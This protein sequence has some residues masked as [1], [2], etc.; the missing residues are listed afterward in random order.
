MTA[1]INK[2]LPARLRLL[3]EAAGLSRAELATRAI[4]PRAPGNNVGR[5]EN[6]A[7]NPTPPTLAKIAFGLGVTADFLTTGYPESP[8][9]SAAGWTV[10]EGFPARLRAASA[11]LGV[12]VFEKSSNRAWTSRAQVTAL[13]RGEICPSPE[14]VV[15]LA[16]VLGISAEWL[17]TGT[18]GVAQPAAP[19]PE[20]DT[21]VEPVAPTTGAGGAKRKR[22]RPAKPKAARPA[23]RRPHN[24]GATYENTGTAPEGWTVDKQFPTRLRT[25]MKT[26]GV[27]NEVLAERLGW[28]T[29]NA[30]NSYTTGKLAPR[31]ET[32]M[33]MAVALGVSGHWLATGTEGEMTKMSEL[34]VG[35]RVRLVRKAANLTRAQL[36]QK[37]GIER[38]G[39]GWLEVQW[40]E[41]GK[42]RPTFA[43]LERVATALNV[44]IDWLV[45]GY[46]RVEARPPLLAVDDNS[47]DAIAVL[48]RDLRLPECV[49]Q[50]I[51]DLRD[52]GEISLISEAEI[53][54]IR[55]ALRA[56]VKARL[57]ANKWGVDKGRAVAAKEALLEKFEARHNARETGRLKSA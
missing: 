39:G 36:A 48:K 50:L 57:D 37:A 6:G 41:Q 25:L 14:A 46:V 49:Q 7:H 18:E 26:T 31:P 55:Y 1:T 11:D 8:R 47:P 33:N 34:P 24:R 51:S 15:A 9:L 21:A 40:W 22:G 35:R 17:A 43:E 52:I 12:D 30:I 56:M 29:A 10:N 32:V 42:G 44:S 19:A 53:K 2:T 23:T 28:T 4:S 3:R 13:S 5:I 54:E 16:D 38:E 27:T 45:E 20:P